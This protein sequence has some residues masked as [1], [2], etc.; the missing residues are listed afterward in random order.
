MDKPIE[1]YD[2][3]IIIDSDTDNYREIA[4]EQYNNYIRYEN[5]DATIV[6]LIVIFHQVM[7]YNT[8]YDSIYDLT[9]FT[10]ESVLDTVMYNKEEIPVTQKFDLMK[11]NLSIHIDDEVRRILDE[12]ED[13]IKNIGFDNGS[14]KGITLKLSDNVDTFVS[15]CKNNISVDL[16]VHKLENVVTI[17]SSR[18]INIYEYDD[19]FEIMTDDCTIRFDNTEKHDSHLWILYYDDKEVGSL[20]ARK[21]SIQSENK[22]KEFI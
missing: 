16:S 5:I 3:N 21:L 12:Y 18:N 15:D 19:V 22:L 7:Q 13:S 9:E 10:N 11:N 20:N 8:I 14:D 6:N 1:G 4:E 17:E 2:D